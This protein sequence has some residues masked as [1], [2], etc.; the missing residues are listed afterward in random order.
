MKDIT[1]REIKVGD[2]LVVGQRRGNSGSLEIRV[3]AGFKDYKPYSWRD[4]IEKKI[5]TTIGSYLL[6]LEKTLIVSRET[7]TGTKYEGIISAELA[8]LK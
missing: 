2:I 8:K 7:F 1:G 3:V 4:D 6:D 5:K